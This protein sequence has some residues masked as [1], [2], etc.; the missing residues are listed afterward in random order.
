MSKRSWLQFILK[1]LLLGII[2]SAMM[3]LFI[4]ELRNGNGF[5]FWP[6]SS[7]NSNPGR[8]SFEHAINRAAPA[9][10]NIYSTS[11]ETRSML[12][13]RQPYERTSLGAGVVM[14]NN[15]YIL[16]CW[17]V[18]QNA[19]S[20]IVGLSDGRT[21][22]A[23]Q[24]GSDPVTDLA[25]LKVTADNL[26]AIPQT[27]L[28][29]A[30]VGDLVLAIGNPY[31]LGQTITQGIVSA[32]GRYSKA[33]QGVAD[34]ANFIQMDAALNEGNSGGALVDSNGILLGINNANFKTIDNRRRVKDVAG[35]FFAVPYELAIKVMQN[36][37]DHGRVIRGYLGVSGTDISGSPGFRI[38]DVAP[39]SPADNAQLQPNDV[40]MAIDDVPIDN[41]AQALNLIAESRPGT[42]LKLDVNRNNQ[43]FTVD[44]NIVELPSS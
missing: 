38:L 32:T 6:V 36:I 1:S 10:V 13:R 34:Y 40:L 21:L 42:V 43:N 37:I 19:D 16:T 20:I 15:G 31:N 35:V 25:V 24:V 14:N 23:E 3:L 5:S 18:I 2:M 12:F 17:H 9:V 8:I 11:Y 26:H 44:V 22:E 27:E 29:N 30:R 33:N 4:P 7:A 28:P 41:A 39:R